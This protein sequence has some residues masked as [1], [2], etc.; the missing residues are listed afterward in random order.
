M[1]FLLI[2]LSILLTSCSTKRYVFQAKFS[3]IDCPVKA[4]VL[5]NDVPIKTIKIKR[6]G[7][8]IEYFSHSFD[9]K[10]DNVISVEYYDAN[11]NLLAKDSIQL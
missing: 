8:K 11:G 4:L 9:K 5:K 7:E 2:L 3:G 10:I 6:C 1:K